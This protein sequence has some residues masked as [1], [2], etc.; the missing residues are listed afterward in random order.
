MGVNVRVW[1]Y[2]KGQQARNYTLEILSW[3]PGLR[4][5][6]IS[7]SQYLPTLFYNETGWVTR[8]GTRLRHLRSAD[9]QL[10]SL[11]PADT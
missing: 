6:I 1:L 3:P 5:Q 7:E 9:T 2:L 10:R 8:A 11:L 4:E